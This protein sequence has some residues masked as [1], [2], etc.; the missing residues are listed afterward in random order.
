MSISE[1]IGNLNDVDLVAERNATELADLVK[2]ERELA[3]EVVKESTQTRILTP[4]SQILDARAEL[5]TTYNSSRAIERRLDLETEDAQRY[6]KGATKEAF[7][8]A[9]AGHGNEFEGINVLQA[10][11]LIIDFNFEHSGNYSYEDV[12]RGTERLIIDDTGVT[13]T[14]GNLLAYP[15][16]LEHGMQPEYLKGYVRFSGNRPKVKMASVQAKVRHSNAVRNVEELRKQIA[17]KKTE[18]EM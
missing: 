17:V 2:A 1:G 14:F 8:R 13:V 4:L 12:P 10:A 16:D 15:K 6:L 11:G 18:A 5:K 3:R 7:I 9:L